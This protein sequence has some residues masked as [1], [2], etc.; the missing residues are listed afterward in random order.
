MNNIHWGKTLWKLHIHFFH[1]SLTLEWTKHCSGFS[2]EHC[3][4]E[5]TDEIH[6]K[7]LWPIRKSMGC[8]FYMWNHEFS[9]KLHKSDVGKLGE[10]ATGG[11]MQRAIL[12]W[13]YTDLFSF[14]QYETGWWEQIIFLRL[15]QLKEI[16]NLPWPQSHHF[17]SLTPPPFFF[18]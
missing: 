10:S 3:L 7:P 16:Q 9:F 2:F 13:L 1:N 4:G 11:Y 18:V 15:T 17:L 14:V 12:R 8:F 6:R 5:A